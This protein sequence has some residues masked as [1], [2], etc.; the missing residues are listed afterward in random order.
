MKDEESSKDSFSSLK[1]RVSFE[2]IFEDSEVMEEKK[3]FSQILNES[4][5]EKGKR[6]NY[7]IKDFFDTFNFIGKEYELHI[8][9]LLAQILKCFEEKI[10][11][12]QFLCNVE[13]KIEN[14]F[15]DIKECEFDFLINNLDVDL[16]KKFIYYLK[17]NILILNFRGNCYDIKDHKNNL[18]SA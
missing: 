4:E 7:E 2:K 3:L 9:I 17:K 12:F 18:S 1:T 16:F 5:D 15:P 10:N 14:I 8:Q 6:K 13:F 11:S